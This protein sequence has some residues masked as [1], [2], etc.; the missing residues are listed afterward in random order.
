M[1]VRLCSQK[2]ASEA[3][4]FQKEHSWR[5]DSEVS[6]WY[7]EHLPLAAARTVQG[8]NRDSHYPPRLIII[9]WQ[10][11]LQWHSGCNDFMPDWISLFR[12]IGSNDT[13]AY[14]GHWRRKHSKWYEQYHFITLT[15]YWLRLTTGSAVR[16]AARTVYFTAH[17]VVF[18]LQVFMMNANCKITS[19]FIYSV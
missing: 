7:R 17:A 1:F 11:S 10:I 3:E 16:L 8:R 12:I 14:Q 4:K 6:V 15:H 2:L 18:R 19:P 9:Q 5:D 13:Q